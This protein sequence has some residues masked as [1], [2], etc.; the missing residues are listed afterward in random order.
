MIANPLSFGY[1]LIGGYIVG[2][3]VKFN[4]EYAFAPNIDSIH[5]I[6]D[7]VCEEFPSLIIAKDKISD[8]FTF[9]SESIYS[10][11]SNIHALYNDTY[12]NYVG[13]SDIQEL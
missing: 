9:T 2:E 5:R 1:Q 3:M 7:V 6:S 8:A 11:V 13:V 12:S 10:L 4:F